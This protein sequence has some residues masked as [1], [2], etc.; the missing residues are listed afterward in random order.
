MVTTY[1]A[2]LRGINVGGK[3]RILMADLR[4]C[5]ESAGYQD[6]RTYIQSGNVVF[7]SGVANRT[8]LTQAI[9][10]TLAEAF[11]YRATVAIRDSEEIRAVVEK[12]PAGF[13]AEP[14]TYRYDVLYLLPPLQPDEALSAL[15][16]KDE[17]DAAWTGPGVVYASRLIE[18]ASQSGLSRLASHPAYQRMTIRNWNTT[19]KLH[20]MMGP[21][22]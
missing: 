1:L 5:L 4:E 18:R 2:L 9:E 11:D 14:D 22:T 19:R 7:R 13:G 16:L 21:D 6:V 20:S 3:N 17:V 8:E 10:V 12:A 15:T